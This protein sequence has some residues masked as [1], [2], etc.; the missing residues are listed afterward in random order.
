MRIL[1]YYQQRNKLHA[2]TFNRFTR[3]NVSEQFQSSDAHTFD[4]NGRCRV[5]VW[6]EFLVELDQTLFI[7][8]TRGSRHSQSAT[9][10]LLC[11]SYALFLF[12]LRHLQD[13]AFHILVCTLYLYPI[14]ST[15]CFGPSISR[16]THVCVL[17]NIP[18]PSVCFLSIYVS[19]CYF[20]V[21]SFRF[22]Y[23]H[24]HRQSPF[25]Y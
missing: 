22:S 9:T 15:V 24:I 21:Y 10:F 4:G 14:Q 12:S 13:P 5:W 16:L 8:G 18:C 1:G 25:I 17:V 11:R 23:L 19:W 6:C 2:W 3:A 7:G 20:P